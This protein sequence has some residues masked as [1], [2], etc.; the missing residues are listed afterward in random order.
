M[1][2][3][4]D[5]IAVRIHRIAYDNFKVKQKKMNDLIA[6]LGVKRKHIPL[7]R[8]ITLASQ[9]KINIASDKDLIKLARKVKL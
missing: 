1:S 3:N 9:N 7:T 2:T 6:D 4:N 8:V 5:L